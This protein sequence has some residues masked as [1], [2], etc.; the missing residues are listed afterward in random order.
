MGRTCT[1]YI[2]KVYYERKFQMSY[3]YM[4]VVVFFVFSELRCE[5]IVR[6]VNI[7]GIVDHYH[8]KLSFIIYLTNIQC[9]CT[10]HMCTCTRTLYLKNI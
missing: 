1:L 6:F 10:A 9:T 5:V 8:L 7:G 4:Y 2:S 3:M